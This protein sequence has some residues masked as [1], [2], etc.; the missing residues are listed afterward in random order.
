MIVRP[1]ART[2]ASMML[3]DRTGADADH[4]QINPG[5]GQLFRP[6]IDGAL[7]V[8]H[9]G[10]QRLKTF[11]MLIDRTGAE[12]TSARQAD[13]R[14]LEA[15]EHG[16]HQIVGSAEFFHPSVRER[17]RDHAA[18]VDNHIRTADFHFAADFFQEPLQDLHIGYLRHP[19]DGDGGIGKN[20][21]GNQRDSA[22]FRFADPNMSF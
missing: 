5:A 16:A 8:R 14:L 20:G 19:F 7:F 1:L 21:R 10:P 22:V 15:S 9:L 3:I 17:H 6:Q 11:D 13:D 18:R 2:A 4:V 12:E